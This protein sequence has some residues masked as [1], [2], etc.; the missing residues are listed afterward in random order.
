M[1]IGAW[2]TELRR[3]G[4]RLV[5]AP[6]FTAIVVL[7][8]ALG[9]GVNT[10][11]FSVLN[12]VLLQDLPYAEPDRLVRVYENVSDW[13]DLEYL[14]A[15]IVTEWREWGEV[16]D[17]LSA[18]YT[19]REV[20]ADLTDGDVP[21]RI[22]VLMVTAGYFETLGVRPAMGRTFEE[23]ESWGAGEADNN[24]Y[25][26][27]SVAVLGHR[28]WQNR[29]G[30]DPGMVGRTIDLD[31]RSYEVVGVMPASFR[32]PI[33]TQADVWLPQDMRPGGGNHWGNF[34][35]TGLARL[36]ED[37]TL[38]AA[39]DRLDVLSAS[40]AETQPEAE[41]ARLVIRPLQADLVGQTRRTMLWILATAAGLVLLTAC[42]NVA[43]LLF[44]RGLGQDRALALRS[45]LG[46]GR[47]RLVASILLEN[48]ILAVLGGALGFVLGWVGLRG[49]LGIAPDALPA[50]TQVR[51][52]LPVF[53]FALSV[54]FAA[55]LVFGLTPA[56]RMSRT[57]PAEVLR[58]GDRASTLGRMA[59]RLRDGLVV[60][61]VAAALVLVTGAI[62]LTRSFDSLLDVPLA[63]EETGVYTFEVH[64]PTSRY[65]SKEERV[66]FHRTFQERLRTIPGVTAVGAVSWL[67]VNGTYHS[68]GTYWDP[69]TPD[70]SNDDGWHS[71]DVRV[72]EGD[73]F[74][75]MGIDL[76]R[77]T[78]PRDV[79]PEGEAVAWINP[80]LADVLMGD[81]D[82][83]GQQVMIGGTEARVVGLV[84]DVPVTSRGDL[85]P[86]SY[87]LHAHADNRNWALIQ[88]VKTDASFE[89]LRRAIRAELSSLDPGLV[90]YRARPFTDI[91]AS[92]RAQDRFATT[93]MA[94]FGI[95]AL[96]LSLIGTYGVLSG[97]VVARTREIGIRMALGADAGAVRGMVLR[98]A[99]ALTVPG[100][101]LGIG[102]AWGT[103]RW[104]E[105]LLFGVD[106]AD[107]AAYAGAVA[108]FVAV[109]LVAGWIPA[110]RA[111]SVDTVEVLTAE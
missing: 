39:Q 1:S 8:L 11:I 86:K 82:P 28:L 45:A 87:L 29:Y 14:R 20:G 40:L 78:A 101:V 104:I 53:L 107:P 10:A 9:V 110:R 19:Y 16:F 97:T 108:V 62:L 99:A 103:S 57:E 46:S 77:G 73:W 22:D 6:G 90:V 42:V 91:L 23:A 67:P 83:V 33:G 51:F 12:A 63:V 55:L 92:V 48:G 17:D 81:V 65:E 80:S 49:L 36:R 88:T 109:G 56:M 44:A 31:G 71:S 15:P 95:L 35:L 2:I 50:V 32:D 60:I 47:G 21:E 59:R 38:E 61:Q 26:A 89:E 96:A 94:A 24:D 72:I 4:R 37:I 105:A 70:G 69:E 5:R 75:A 52:G 34:F 100:V 64:L 111:T 93:L 3:A 43:N 27:V 66:A 76:L 106:A 74:E 13:G 79:D 98:Y 68:W 7:T 102:L 85:R 18:L 58:S 54:T 41:G 25:A 30:A 84:E